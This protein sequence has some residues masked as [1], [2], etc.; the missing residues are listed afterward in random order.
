MAEPKI[1]F[2]KD[3]ENQYTFSTFLR[4]GRSNL[5]ARCEG[6]PDKATCDCESPGGNNADRAF[7][8]IT[9]MPE[10]TGNHEIKLIGSNKDRN[11][12][13]EVLEE[14]EVEIEVGEK[15]W[16]KKYWLP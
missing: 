3:T 1:F 2:Y 4:Q 12:G 14:E 5:D 8:T 6:L 16:L 13:N 7:C 11:G 15:Q 10:A 9:W